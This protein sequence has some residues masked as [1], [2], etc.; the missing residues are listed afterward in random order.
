GRL[1]EILQI[2]NESSIYDYPEFWLPNKKKSKKSTKKSLWLEKF[3]RN[4][5]NDKKVECEFIE[6]VDQVGQEE[7]RSS[8]RRSSRRLN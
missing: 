4:K 2:K 5:L 3:K 1:K 8:P 7:R 6:H